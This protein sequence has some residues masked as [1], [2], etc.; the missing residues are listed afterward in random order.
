MSINQ[1]YM[2]RPNR[3]AVFY[4]E[5]TGGG[6][7]AAGTETK[8]TGAEGQEDE[9]SLLESDGSEE[10]K[11]GGERGDKLDKSGDGQPGDGQPGEAAPI[12]PTD[13]KVPEGC[14]WDEELGNP[15]LEALSDAKLSPKERAQKVI[16]M[17]PAFQE[18][19]FASMK[20]AYE[21]EH[22]KIL[23]DAAKAEAEWKKAS[24]ADPEFGGEMFM[25]NKRIINA[26]RDKLA[27]PGARKLMED[28]KI[29]DHPEILR[30]FYRAGKL[31]GEDGTG[32]GSRSAVLLTDE[33][34][35]YGKGG[36]K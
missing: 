16:D 23:D 25:A 26:G 20:A 30:M 27:T 9:K 19:F 12:A 10:G 4:A 13:L 18:K 15:F 33:E 35:F 2:G 28:L 32:Q 24:L 17:I 14:E 5:E 1:L 36:S 31:L 8:E 11:E 7:G 34:V 6:D 29:G 3:A 22:K 21:A